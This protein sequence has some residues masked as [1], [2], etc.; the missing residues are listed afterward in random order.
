M[1]IPA[2]HGGYLISLLQQCLTLHFLTTHEALNQPYT[3]ALHNE[4]LRPASTGEVIVTISDVRLGKA[5]STIHLTLTQNQSVKC[6]A[7]ATQAGPRAS[8]NTITQDFGYRINPTLAPI[9]F[10]A[11]LAGTDRNWVRSDMGRDPKVPNHTLC[12]VVFCMQRYP[13]ESDDWKRMTNTWICP[14]IEE[15]RWTAGM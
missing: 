14:R 1:K 7:Y 11:V 9:N 15:E 5:T 6:V 8:L 4:F 3:T 12:N 13:N 10:D 2:A